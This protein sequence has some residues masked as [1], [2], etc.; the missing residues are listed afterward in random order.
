M[1]GDALTPEARAAVEQG[2]A[3][4]RAIGLAEAAAF[5]AGLGIGYALGKQGAPLGTVRAQ[6]R[7]AAQVYVTPAS[8]P[9]PKRPRRYVATGPDGKQTTIEAVEG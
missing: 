6:Y 9:A 3:I 4:A 2:S 8:P 7:S 1:A 5:N